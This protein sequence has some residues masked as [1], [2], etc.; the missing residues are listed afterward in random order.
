MLENTEQGAGKQ[1]EAGAGGCTEGP[2]GAKM[3]LD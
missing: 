2:E 3:G 1:L